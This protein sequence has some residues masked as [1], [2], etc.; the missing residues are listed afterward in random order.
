MSPHQEEML[1]ELHDAIVGNEKLGHMGLVKRMNA[2]EQSVISYKPAIQ[3]FVDRKNESKKLRTAII[4][5]CVTFVVGL[6]LH[7]TIFLLNK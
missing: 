7:L 2:V 5:S 3:S 1:K 4:G 6:A